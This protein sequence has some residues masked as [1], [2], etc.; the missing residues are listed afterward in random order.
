MWGGGRPRVRVTDT[1][2]GHL[3][4][5]TWPDRALMAP[6]L[7]ISS[8]LIY[9]LHPYQPRYTESHRRHATA[10]D[11]FM[12]V[13]SFANKLVHDQLAIGVVCSL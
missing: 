13:T 10:R 12:A 1:G 4:E 9:T 5:M 11:P 8:R 3:R 7:A 6:V 2:Q